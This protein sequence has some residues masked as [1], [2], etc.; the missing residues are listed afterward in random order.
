MDPWMARVPWFPSYV[1]HG[2]LAFTEN[3]SF[4]QR[5]GNTFFNIIWTTLPSVLY[6]IPIDED[7]LKFYTDDIPDFT[8]VND[9]VA[10]SELWL[11]TTN[12]YIDYVKPMMADMVRTNIG[13]QTLYLVMSVDVGR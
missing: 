11:I 5:L 4:L 9:L 10:E 2:L 1:P 3:M 6:D 12:E 8:S 7:V 13:Y